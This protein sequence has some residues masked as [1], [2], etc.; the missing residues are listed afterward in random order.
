MHVID[1]GRV[2]DRGNSRVRKTLESWHVAITCQADN[3]S[4]QLPILNFIVI[5][6]ML[7]AFYFRT[8]ISF[9]FFVVIYIRSLFSHIFV[10]IYLYLRFSHLAC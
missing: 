2:I 5:L 10:H 8:S 7:L 4:K 1:T 3:N 9:T 6:S